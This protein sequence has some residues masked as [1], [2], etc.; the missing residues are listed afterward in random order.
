MNTSLCASG[1]YEL[2]GVASGGGGAER[3]GCSDKYLI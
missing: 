2:Q 3:G 1:D